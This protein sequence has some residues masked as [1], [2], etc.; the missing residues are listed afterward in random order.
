MVYLFLSFALFA[1]SR[2]SLFMQKKP[3]CC[4]FEHNEVVS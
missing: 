2:F 1:L 4:H 3:F